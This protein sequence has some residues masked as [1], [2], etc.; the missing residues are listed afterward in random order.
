MATVE[1]AHTCSLLCS[2][3][4][5]PHLAVFDPRI[6]TFSWISPFGHGYV[7]IDNQF[8]CAVFTSFD[9]W[10]APRVDRERRRR[11][12]LG[13]VVGVGVVATT[14]AFVVLTSSSA[15]AQEQEELVLEAQL[16]KEP[17]PQPEPELEI[18]PK[19]KASAPK[20]AAPPPKAAQPT[21]IPREPLKEADASKANLA[22]EGDPFERD[23]KVEEA[24]PAATAQAVAA[25]EPPPRRAAVKPE[26]VAPIR[27]TEEVTPPVAAAGN[28]RPE[29]PSEAKSAGVEGVVLVKYVVKEDGTV[30]DVRVIKGP[31]ELSGVC[32][33]AVKSWRF[34]PA[35]LDGKPVA[36][37][38]V[39]R[40]PFKIRT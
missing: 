33:E 8:P 30:T 32:I 7:T 9:E 10:V 2:K 4:S 19:P 12:M 35:I 11:L 29:Y 3:A 31:S 6:L 22:D 13:Y 20:P 28:I 37:V 14:G 40:F 26:K 24:K 34:S 1:P 23:T 38:R 25:P 39:A 5:V 27:V 17:E 16:A 18:A 21:E 36:V 15:K